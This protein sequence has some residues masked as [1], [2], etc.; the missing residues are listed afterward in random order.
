MERQHVYRPRCDKST[1]R[2]AIGVRCPPPARH[3]RGKTRLVTSCRHPMTPQTPRPR[4]LQ[5]ESAPHAGGAVS[6]PALHHR[7]P[8]AMMQPTPRTAGLGQRR[9]TSKANV[10]HLLGGRTGRTRSSPPP[11]WWNRT[12]CSIRFHC[13]NPPWPLPRTPPRPERQQALPRPK[14]A[15]TGGSGGGMWPM[16]V[17]VAAHVVHMDAP[18]RL[19]WPG[20]PR[21]AGAVLSGPPIPL[22]GG[23]NARP[24]RSGVPAPGSTARPVFGAGPGD[25]C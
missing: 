19:P 5:G 9:S 10:V 25:P 15:A 23:T 11:A 22:A 14:P 17:G 2:T 7:A 4:C 6:S 1:R 20:Q 8:A 3:L 16:T 13:P 12:G 18:P 24:G 21:P